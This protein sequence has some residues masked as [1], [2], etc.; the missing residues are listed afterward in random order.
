MKI[1]T[2]HTSPIEVTLNEED[3]KNITATYLEKLFDWN[4][5]YF[6]ENR[7][8]KIWTTHYSSHSW[9]SVDVVR[10]ATSR[11]VLVEKIFQH[12]YKS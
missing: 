9:D 12:L 6:I 5:N 1:T 8:V 4:R 7:E 3:Q 11:D 10:K 2:Q